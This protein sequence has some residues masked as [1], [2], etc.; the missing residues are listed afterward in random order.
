MPPPMSD[1]APTIADAYATECTAIDPGRGIH[2]GKAMRG[3]F[4]MPKKRL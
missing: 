1:F 2:D 4:G 3:V